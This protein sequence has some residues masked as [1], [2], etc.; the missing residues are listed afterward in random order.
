MHNAAIV[1]LLKRHFDRVLKEKTRGNR[2]V[3][4]RVRACAYAIL[5]EIGYSVGC[6]SLSFGS[7]LLPVQ[8]FYCDPLVIESICYRSRD[9]R[10][11]YDCLAEIKLNGCCLLWPKFIRGEAFYNQNIVRLVLKIPD[12]EDN[13]RAIKAEYFLSKFF[14]AIQSYCSRLSVVCSRVR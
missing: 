14:S 7:C 11:Q 1:H 6:H 10:E 5:T 13:T 8:I 3:C 2:C 12:G 9:K 4:V